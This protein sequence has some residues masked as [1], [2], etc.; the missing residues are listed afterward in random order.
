M[1]TGTAMVVFVRLRWTEV[2]AGKP[3]K[4]VLAS[5]KFLTFPPKNRKECL[6]LQSQRAVQD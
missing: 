6:R 5:G 1:M 2:E 3:V 4:S